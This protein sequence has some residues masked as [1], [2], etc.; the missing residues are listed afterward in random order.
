MARAFA[1]LGEAGTALGWAT[2]A[3]EQAWAD[4]DPYTDRWNL[5]QAEALITALG[6][7]LGKLPDPPSGLRPAVPHRRTIAGLLARRTAS[8]T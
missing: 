2:R 7:R 1:A 5:R 4:G 3:R 8:R 6:G